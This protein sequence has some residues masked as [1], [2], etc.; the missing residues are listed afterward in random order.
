MR[1]KRDPSRSGPAFSAPE[2]HFLPLPAASPSGQPGGNARQ[3]FIGPFV[4]ILFVVIFILMMQ[5]L[6][7]YIDELVGKGLGLRTILEFLFWGVC[8]LAL[9]LALPLATLL[10][11]TM[12]VGQ[13]P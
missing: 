3:A 6:W 5:T 4:A 12:T 9:P 2:G 11:S 8:S 10:A 7:L 13:L 1:K